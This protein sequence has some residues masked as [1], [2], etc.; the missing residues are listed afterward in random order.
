MGIVSRLFNSIDGIFWFPVIA[1][2]IFVIF[3]VLIVIH[4]LTMDKSKE[5]E[6]EILPFEND[7][8]IHSNEV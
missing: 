7:E 6:C 4:T 2:A 8:K 3:F 5:E 1:L